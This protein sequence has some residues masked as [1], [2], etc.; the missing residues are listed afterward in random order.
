MNTINNTSFGCGHC[1]DAANKFVKA[2]IPEVLAKA[3]V[4]KDVRASEHCYSAGHGLKAQKYDFSLQNSPAKFE[5]K[6]ASLQEKSK[7]LDTKA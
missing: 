2:G 7:T 4:A 3:Q 1:R 5:K 6:L